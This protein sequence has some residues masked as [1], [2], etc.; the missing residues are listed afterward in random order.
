MI[1]YLLKSIICSALLLGVYYLVLEKEKMHRF[2]RFYLLAAFIISWLIPLI[3]FKVSI[4]KITEHMQTAVLPAANTFI[5][6]QSS[7]TL[8]NTDIHSIPIN[9]LP[10]ILW[11]VYG[12]ITL[13][14]LVRFVMNMYQIRKQIVSRKIEKFSDYSLVII[15]DNEVS[16]S[17]F[18]YIFP[19]QSD[20][21]NGTMNSDI[22]LH[23]TAHA[24]E[25]HSIDILFIELCKVFLWL[26]PFVFLYKKTIQLN[27]EFI[28]DDVVVGQNKDVFNYQSLLLSKITQFPISQLVSTSNYSITKKRFIMM[29]K[30]TSRIRMM[31]LKI[32]VIPIVGILVFGF[33]KKVVASPKVATT[34]DFNEISFTTNND[35]SDIVSSYKTLYN[36]MIQK[37]K[38][39]KGYDTL[40]YNGSRNAFLNLQRMYKSMNASQKSKV[41]SLPIFVT[42]SLDNPFPYPKQERPTEAQIQKWTN[43]PELWAIWYNDK[44]IKNSDLENYSM[45]DFAHY[46]AYALAQYIRPKMGYNVE[47]HIE[48]Q[49]HYNEEVKS[50]RK[51]LDPIQGTAFSISKKKR[52]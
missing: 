41:D 49:A 10:V 52:N 9:C 5:Q 18:N 36:S 16:F 23:E 40:H 13:I 2:N 38:N 24:K 7:K 37:G 28:A 25:K 4:P 35:D 31:C 8:M 29:N 47:I 43:H 11:S 32:G 14:F 50:Y 6:A 33:G 48:D 46:H 19:A 26:N 44:R 21:A 42:I 15:P 45:N 12:T 34:Q 17:F 30:K 1:T 27:H 22:F 39:Q 20:Y 3:T 51:W